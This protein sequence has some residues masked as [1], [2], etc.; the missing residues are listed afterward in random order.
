[1]QQET[2][3]LLSIVVKDCLLSPLQCRHASI[4]TSSRA[5]N[6]YWLISCLWGHSQQYNYCSFALYEWKMCVRSQK[7]RKAISSLHCQST[8]D[9]CALLCVASRGEK[10]SIDIAAISL[11]RLNLWVGPVLPCNLLPSPLGSFQ[12]ASG[13]ERGEKAA[14]RSDNYI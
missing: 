3:N 10:C 4:I 5:H 13:N 2:Y 12:R 7:E 11:P 1:M 8:H 6:S 14:D 9:S